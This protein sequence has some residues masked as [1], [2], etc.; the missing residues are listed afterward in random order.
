MAAMVA[1]SSDNSV[2]AF[3]DSLALLLA[4]TIT[5]R[6]KTDTTTMAV[7]M[8]IF[9]IV[10]FFCLVMITRLAVLST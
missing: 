4:L 5:I 2:L 6:A 8:R 1:I 7:R 3:F 10:L 9:F